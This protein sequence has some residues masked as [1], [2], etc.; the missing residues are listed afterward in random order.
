MRPFPS[1]DEDRSTTGIFSEGP[2]CSNTDEQ[3][4]REEISDGD[5]GGDGDP[6]STGGGVKPPLDDEEPSLEGE[7]ERLVPL[8]SSIVA[9][10]RR[11]EENRKQESKGM[12]DGYKRKTKEIFLAMEHRGAIVTGIISFPVR[13]LVHVALKTVHH[14][15]VIQADKQIVQLFRERYTET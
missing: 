1:E 11:R 2:P 7:R 14:A 3:G 5:P 9:K 8:L 10:R 6:D 15:P 4:R 12:Q 13:P